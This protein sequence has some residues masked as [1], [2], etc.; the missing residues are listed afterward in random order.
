MMLN[1]A[2]DNHPYFAFDGQPNTDPIDVQ[3]DGGDSTMMGGVWP[4]QACNAWGANLNTR[5]VPSPL[6]PSS[7]PPTK[8]FLDVTVGQTLVL[9]L[10]E[11]SPT[12][13]TIVDCSF[14]VWAM[15][16]SLVGAVLCLIMLISGRRL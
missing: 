6:S 14:V 2:V 4:K 8:S 11:S 16:L 7:P 3:A 10:L 12:P 15:D 5:Y 9:Q 1:V 13:S